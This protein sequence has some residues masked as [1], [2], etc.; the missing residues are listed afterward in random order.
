[1]TNEYRDIM[2]Q[3]FTYGE[4]LRMFV[5]IN[6]LPEEWFGTPDHIAYKCQN[7]QHFDEVIN[8]AADDA[9]TMSVVV[10]DNRRLASARLLQ[11]VYVE[12]FGTVQWLEIMEPRPEKVG[13]D[14]VGLEH[15]EFYWPHFEYAEEVLRDRGVSYE[16]QGNAS[17][18]WITIVINESGQEV[19]LNNRPLAD[20]VD[21]ELSEGT[22][23]SIV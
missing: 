1:M 15:M 6:A 9:E 19:K 8:E 18:Q 10:L 20:S 21:E 4:D 3:I 13:V 7:G 5:D 11:P 22:A 23:E 14:G 17:H 12:S 16:L 2:T